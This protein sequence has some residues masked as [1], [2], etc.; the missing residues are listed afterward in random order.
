MPLK[1]IGQLIAYSWEKVGKKLI[2]IRN[3]VFLARH[4]YRTP[5]TSEEYTVFCPSQTSSLFQ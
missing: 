5:G 1:S 4:E 2:S 3:E